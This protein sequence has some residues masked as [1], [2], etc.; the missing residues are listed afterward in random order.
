MFT[1]TET[2]FWA[3]VA[4]SDPSANGLTDPR[5]PVAQELA[6]AR[7]S[8]ARGRLELVADRDNL[9]V[10]AASSYRGID[11]IPSSELARQTIRVRRLGASILAVP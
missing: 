11:S 5:I 9:R 7:Q 2:D 3:I 1:G 6:V 4:G 10:S 8:W